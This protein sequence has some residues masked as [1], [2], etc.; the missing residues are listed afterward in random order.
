MKPK[1]IFDCIVVTEVKVQLFEGKSV[2]HVKGLAEIVLNDQIIIRGI[3][4]NMGE[5]GLFISYPI[6]PFYKGENLRSIAFPI[7]RNLREHI[8]AVILEKYNEQIKKN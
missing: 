3:R 7:T 8:E 5:N 6:D 4:I 2:G 1:E